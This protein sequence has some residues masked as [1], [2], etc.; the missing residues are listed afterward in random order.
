MIKSETLGQRL[1]RL[2]QAAH[3]TQERL[4][5]ETGLAVSNIRNWEQGHRTP[6]I[7]ALLKIARA[8]AQPMEAFVEGVVRSKKAADRG[9]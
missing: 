8:L 4:A 5:A 9:K 3:F 6:N 7:F 1:R 2:R